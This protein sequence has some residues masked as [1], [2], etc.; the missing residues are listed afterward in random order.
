MTKEKWQIERD[1]QYAKRKIA[2]KSL[3]K[4]QLDAIYETHSAL[5]ES[6]SMLFECQDLYLSD[7]R[8]LDLAFYKLKNE[9]NIEDK[10]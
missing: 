9:F 5:S 4:K 6:L 10:N 1:K 7:I 3:T 8:K 2:M